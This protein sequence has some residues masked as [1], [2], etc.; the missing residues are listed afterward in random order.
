MPA[1]KISLEQLLAEMS[2]GKAQGSLT[3]IA[4]VSIDGQWFDLEDR[5]HTFVT[6]TDEFFA[7]RCLTF[8]VNDSTI[9]VPVQNV[10]AI[11]VE[12]E[13]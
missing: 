10:T 12:T 4:A 5:Q 13:S 9:V 8:R 11:R 7:D 1:D 3:H 6:G 2:G